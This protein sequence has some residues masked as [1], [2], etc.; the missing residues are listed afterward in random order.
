MLSMAL[1]TEGSKVSVLWLVD[2]EVSR[3]EPSGLSMEKPDAELLAVELCE[4]LED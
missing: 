2:E 4:S 1:D 3:E